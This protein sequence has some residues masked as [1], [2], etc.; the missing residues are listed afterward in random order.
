MNKAEIVKRLVNIFKDSSWSFL[1][2]S[3]N[4]LSQTCYTSWTLFKWIYIFKQLFLFY[5]SGSVV[6]IP[7]KTAKQYKGNLPLSPEPKDTSPPLRTLVSA[8]LGCLHHLPMHHGLCWSCSHHRCCYH[9]HWILLFPLTLMCWGLGGG[10]VSAVVRWKHCL[11]TQYGFAP[12]S[13]GV[14]TP[15]VFSSQDLDMISWS[16]WQIAATA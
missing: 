14:L 15:S 2:L 12:V 4:K 1:S 5:H 9:S 13:P 10:R 8:E 3:P 16:N 6:D 7:A 11:P